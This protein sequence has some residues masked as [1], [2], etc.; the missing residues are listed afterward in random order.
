[1]SRN[2]CP[3]NKS[4]FAAYLTTDLTNFAISQYIRQVA[5]LYNKIMKVI[6]PPGPL[7][8]FPLLPTEFYLELFSYFPLKA[9]VA[10]RGACCAWRNLFPTANIPAACRL[11]LEL[12]LKL[13]EGKYFHRTRPWVLHNLK[14]FNREAYVAALV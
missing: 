5:S 11:L 6:T 2:H 3:R 13:I 10:L 12:Y 4:I 9:L 8:T 7:T 14:D 1:M